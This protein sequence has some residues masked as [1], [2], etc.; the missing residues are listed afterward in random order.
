MGLHFG[1]RLTATAPE[2]GE[3]KKWGGFIGGLFCLFVNCTSKLP[4][5]WGG[6]VELN[7]QRSPGGQRPRCAWNQR[8]E[9]GAAAPIAQCPHLSPHP[10]AQRHPPPIPSL[11]QASNRST[12]CGDG[13]T[14]RAVWGAPPVPMGQQWG[15]ERSCR[16]R[17]ITRGSEN[18]AERTQLR[19]LCF[20]PS[21]CPLPSATDWHWD[22][23]WGGGGESGGCGDTPMGLHPTPGISKVLSALG[24][25]VQDPPRECHAELRVQPP[26]GALL[27]WGRGGLHTHSPHLAPL[28]P[29]RSRDCL[30]APTALS[31][32]KG[33]NASSAPP[34]PNTHRGG[35]GK[36]RTFQISPKGLW[37][38]TRT[39]GA[40]RDTLHPWVLRCTEPKRLQPHP[41]PPTA[42]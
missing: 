11:S 35:Q 8:W 13:H 17:V 2:G 30:Y 14:H 25:G 26:S 21:H 7:P 36:G 28:R 18:S 6:D 41:K 34:L 37:K 31:N 38:R 39:V 1:T 29:G 22:A 33:S 23:G 5:W 9:E 42:P 32:E 40:P 24:W 20:Q 12:C 19:A 10:M 27:L 4:H 16:R 15:W 3:V